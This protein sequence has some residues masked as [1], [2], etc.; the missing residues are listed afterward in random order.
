MNSFHIQI[1]A[2][3]RPFYEGPCESI[4]IPTNDGFYGIQANHVNTIHAVV[5]GQFTYRI[6]GGNDE[7]AVIGSGMVKVENNEVL[8][9]IESIE[10]PEEIDVNRARRAADRAKEEILQ[11]RSMREYTLAQA[12]LSRALNRL[13]VKKHQHHI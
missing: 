5:P 3:D 9:L 2:T 1:F 12:N 13:K 8:M 10:R 7:I 11:K 4:I 6:P